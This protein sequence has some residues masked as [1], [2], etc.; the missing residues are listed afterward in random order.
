MIGSA[1]L[2]LFCVMT[3]AYLFCT[4][5]GRVVAAAGVQN[6][7]SPLSTPDQTRV[8]GETK[9]ATKLVAKPWNN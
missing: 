7:R 2:S 8:E 9:I 1:N 6:A 3:A 5:K 4:A